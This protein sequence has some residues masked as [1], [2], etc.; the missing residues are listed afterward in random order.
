MRGRFITLEG[1]EGT[2]KSTQARHLAAWLRA[3]GH[4]V[5]E[6]REPGGSSGAEALRAVLVDAP[7][8]GWDAVGEALL[9]SAARRDHLR[10]V[11]WPALRRGDWVVCDRFADSTLAYQG[12]GHGLAPETLEVL[13]EL[14]AGPFGPDLTLVLDLDPNV[15]LMRARAR[16]AVTR[17]EALDIAFHARVRLGFL[18]IAGHEPERC[19]VIAADGDEDTVTART[20]KAVQ[21]RIEAWSAD[22][23][24]LTGRVS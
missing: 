23:G 9:L 21:A 16:G 1:G 11:I 7:V 3:R 2:G 5:V 14:V 18:D 8:D 10:H 22:E 20:I 19:T 15:G 17:F 4:T 24:M 13:Y 6:T 12:H